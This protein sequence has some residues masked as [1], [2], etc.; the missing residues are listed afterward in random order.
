MPAGTG[1]S[2]SDIACY[3]RGM[4]FQPV[5]WSRID[6]VLL[7]MD[8]TLLDLQF[9]NWFWQELVPQRYAHANGLSVERSRAILDPKFRASMG[10]LNWYCIDFWSRE[11][12]LDI[13]AIKQ[14][15]H[16]Q[17][18]F[19][20]GAR[21]FLTALHGMGKRRVLITNA[22][23][24]TLDIKDR[25]VGLSGFLDAV[26][27]TH[28]FGAPKEHPQFWPRFQAAEPF[29]PQRTLFIDDSL[30]VLRAA[31]EFGIGQLRAVRHPDSRGEARDTGE[32]I[33]IDGVAQLLG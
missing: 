16:E 13:P 7:D 9:D 27:S 21:P 18:R 4:D 31:R 19:L 14:G 32:F 8:G 1:A 10:T 11:L 20:P 15:V 23:P 28:P 17:V 25:R 12:G 2:G 29:D 6:I 30:P 33:G 26:H 3:H 5:D 22:H 24:A